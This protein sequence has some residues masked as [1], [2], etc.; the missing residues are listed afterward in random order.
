MDSDHESSNFCSNLLETP[1]LLFSKDMVFVN[2][3]LIWG[4]TTIA[5]W[6]GLLT[7]IMTL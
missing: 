3:N 6:A 1:R 5:F 4:G 7:P 2:M